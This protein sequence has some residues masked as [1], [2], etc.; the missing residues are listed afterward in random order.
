M[1]DFPWIFGIDMLFILTDVPEI[2]S[3][4]D[5]MYYLQYG[6]QFASTFQ[7]TKEYTKFLNLS[8]SGSTSLR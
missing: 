7:Y 5:K 3:V 6:D 4:S 1:A 8:L 2:V